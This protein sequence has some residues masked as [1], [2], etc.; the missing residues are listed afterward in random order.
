MNIKLE[1]GLAEEFRKIVSEKNAIDV[2]TKD[3]KSLVNNLLDN[4]FKESRTTIEKFIEEK[5]VK[6]NDINQKIKLYKANYEDDKRQF[7]NTLVKEYEKQY[8]ATIEKK[9]KL[10]SRIPYLGKIV[11]TYDEESY[12]SLDDDSKV[13]LLLT[14]ISM[15]KLD[16]IDINVEKCLEFNAKLFNESGE[17]L[18][19]VKETPTYSSKITVES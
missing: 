15:D 14:L 19:G 4:E 16:L 9:T 5:E 11:V 3:K 6:E 1:R 13:E 7:S 12:L 18:P 10:E 2:L 8:G 17:K